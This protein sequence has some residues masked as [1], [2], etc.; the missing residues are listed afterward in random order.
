MKKI[1]LSLICLMLL[2]SRLPPASAQDTTK[3]IIR[4]SEIHRIFSKPKML[5]P[6]MVESLVVLAMLSEEYPC[7]AKILKG[8]Q[9]DCDIF[10]KSIEDTDARLF[11][12]AAIATVCGFIA[13]TDWQPEWL[14]IMAEGTL[15]RIHISRL[16]L[17]TAGLKINYYTDRSLQLYILQSTE[18]IF[19]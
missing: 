13:D 6:E 2:G 5:K 10:I 8:S 17:I 19:E 4:A 3:S 12:G 11:A 15:G 18:V 14:Y 7:E 1:V 16:L 9:S